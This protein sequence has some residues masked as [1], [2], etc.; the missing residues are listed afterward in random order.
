MTR[1]PIVV[2]VIAV[3]IV[4]IL[5][6]WTVRPISSTSASAFDPAA[7]VASI[8][9]T[10]VRQATTEAMAIGSVAS[11]DLTAG[12]SL[13]VQGVGTVAAADS[14]S[15]VGLVRIH[16]T[17]GVEADVQVGPVI[18]GTAIRDAL[19]FIQFSDFANQID[20]AQ[21]ASL[22]NERVLEQLRHLPTPATLVGRRMRV[23]GALRL[24]GSSWEITPISLEVAGGPQ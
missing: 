20:Y 4:A 22:L 12:R 13:F 6:P 19:P 3:A 10:R 15:R 24:A 9:D 23:V 8:W 1:V 11:R 18:R 7:Y 5:R 14:H 16:F 17:E 2:G 21:V